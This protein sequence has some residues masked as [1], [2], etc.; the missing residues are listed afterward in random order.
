MELISSISLVH[1]VT[2]LQGPL[3]GVKEVRQRRYSLRVPL[4]HSMHECAPVK[5]D[6][7]KG[8]QPLN[9][10]LQEARSS[11]GGGTRETFCWIFRLDVIVLLVLRQTYRTIFNSSGTLTPH[12]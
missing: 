4:P 12:F 7:L 3:C 5:I 11:Q 8:Q 6:L 1:K 2:V 10:L 9:L